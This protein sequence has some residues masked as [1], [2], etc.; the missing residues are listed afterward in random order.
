M[1]ESS[2]V[3]PAAVAPAYT[4]DPKHSDEKSSAHKVAVGEVDH[5][6]HLERRFGFWSCLGMA[7]IML[8][9]WTGECARS[10]RAER[11]LALL[12]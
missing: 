9:S 10:A 12:A 11:A 8:N 7:F 4:A 1:S 5:T 6:V 3:S 2:G